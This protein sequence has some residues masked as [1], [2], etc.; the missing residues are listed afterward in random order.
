MERAAVAYFKVLFKNSS[1]GTEGNHGKPHIG[2]PGN[3]WA[4]G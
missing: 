4:P 1:R 2:L 3:Y